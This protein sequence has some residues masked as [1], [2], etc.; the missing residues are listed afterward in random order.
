M[1]IEV[2]FYIINLYNF[3]EL[4]IATETLVLKKKKQTTDTR[5]DMVGP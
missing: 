2:L 3:Q 5:N 4:E 1:F